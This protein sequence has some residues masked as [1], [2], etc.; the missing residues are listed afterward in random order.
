M[1][2]HLTTNPLKVSPVKPFVW[3]L[4]SLPRLLP[5]SEPQKAKVGVEVVVGSG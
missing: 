2:Y 1:T 4:K 3:I 5:P